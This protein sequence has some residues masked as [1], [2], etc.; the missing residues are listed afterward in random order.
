MIT[1]ADRSHFKQ[2]TLYPQFTKFLAFLNQIENLSNF[3][4]SYQLS[5]QIHFTANISKHSLI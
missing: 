4:K 5:F 2:V 1:E 3:L